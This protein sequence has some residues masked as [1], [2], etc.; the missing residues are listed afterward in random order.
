MNGKELW[1]IGRTYTL[2]G[3]GMILGFVLIM[4]DKIPNLVSLTEWTIF[5]GTVMGF[6]AAKSVGHAIA[7]K[8][9]GGE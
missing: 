8:K 1:G 9:G 5:V 6:Y 3:S 4:F 7:N 2:A